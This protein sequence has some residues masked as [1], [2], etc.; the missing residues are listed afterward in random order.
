MSACTASRRGRQRGRSDR[1][2]S[3]CGRQH[4]ARLDRRQQPST[5]PD[6]GLVP[7]GAGAS[8]I[9]ARSPEGPGRGPDLD[10][11]TRPTV[12]APPAGARL[13]RWVCSGGS[14]VA[15]FGRWWPFAGAGRAC[16]YCH[17]PC[18][19]RLRVKGG[20]LGRPRRGC[21]APLTPRVGT[22]GRPPTPATAAPI[23]RAPRGGSP[24]P[25]GPPAP[26]SPSR[27]LVTVR[28]GAGVP[29]LVLAAGQVPRRDRE[30][31]HAARRERE[32]VR[33]RPR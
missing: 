11:S 33:Y 17:P 6:T 12:A 26:R 3:N 15:P 10:V 4:A 32:V 31:A 27:S 19:P 20:R 1:R 25:S 2:R 13:A 28:A 18:R 5:A 23:R 14:W 8:T 21:E 24:D 7:G 30:P 29:V 9:P 22:V 16:P